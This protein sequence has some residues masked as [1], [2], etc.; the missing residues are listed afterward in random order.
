[1]W[2][3]MYIHIISDLHQIKYTSIRVTVKCHTMDIYGIPNFT[4]KDT[5]SPNIK[6]LNFIYK[7]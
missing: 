7:Y 6:M 2:C 4:I 3:S 5:I 1:M